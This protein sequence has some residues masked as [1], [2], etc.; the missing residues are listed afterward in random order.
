MIQH[1]VIAGIPLDK[2]PLGRAR[3]GVRVR[4]RVRFGGVKRCRC[5]LNPRVRFGG[6]KRCRCCRLSSGDFYVANAAQRP[7]SLTLQGRWTIAVVCLPSRVSRTDH[8][9]AFGK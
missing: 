2:A 4:V 9:A 1:F 5:Y 8:Y 3:V 6:V 7:V